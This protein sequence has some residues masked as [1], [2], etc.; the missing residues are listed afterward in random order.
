MIV[1]VVVI[2]KDTTKVLVVFK[3]EYFL[4]LLNMLQ[5]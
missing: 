1:D 5:I 4:L 2:T 3:E